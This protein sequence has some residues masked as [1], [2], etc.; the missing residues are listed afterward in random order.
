MTTTIRSKYDNEEAQIAR[1]RDGVALTLR[2]AH[3]VI[4]PRAEFIEAVAA[5]L[6]VIVIPRADLPEVT[7]SPADGRIQARG[8]IL[9]NGSATG[10]DALGWLAINEHLDAH[11]PV[12][13]ADV[14]ALADAIASVGIPGNAHSSPS[15]VLAR[16]LL[17]TG[18]VHVGGAR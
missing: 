13:E 14:E 18:Q 9:H 3:S 16:R 1:R 10:G 6:D 17:A 7:V 8:A 12:D 11:P 15:T 4:L 5:E 2:S